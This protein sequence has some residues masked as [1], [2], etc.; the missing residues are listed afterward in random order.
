MGEKQIRQ[1]ASDPA[2]GDR[3]ARRYTAA[4][5]WVMESI[6]SGHYLEAVAVLDSLLSDRLAS[7]SWHIRKV[8]PTSRDTVKGLC[9]KSL[10]GLDK[11][12][13]PAV[14]TDESFVAVIKSI[15]SWADARNE[16]IHATAKIFSIEDP[17]VGFHSVLKIHRSTALDEVRLLQELDELDTASRELVGRMSG[18]YPNAFFPDR[19][20]RFSRKEGWL[21][22][23]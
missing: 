5:D 6:E 8:P 19:R 15:A 10:N 7:R 21:Q 13:S 3:R 1:V 2:F 9:V 16:A 11:T 14:E 20:P 22:F 18:T 4:F 17:A 23:D 12:D